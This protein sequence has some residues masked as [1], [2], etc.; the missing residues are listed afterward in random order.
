MNFIFAFLMVFTETIIFII[1]IYNYFL[2]KEFIIKTQ[3]S[4]GKYDLLIERLFK[5]RPFTAGKRKQSNF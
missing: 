5:M 1:Y 2:Y 3:K 4:A